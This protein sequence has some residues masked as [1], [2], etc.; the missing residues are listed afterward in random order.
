MKR[1]AEKVK[2]IVEICPFTHLHDFA[3]DPGLTLASYHFTDITADLMSKWIDRASGVRTGQGAALALA[4]FRGVGK[5]HFISVLAAIVSRPELRSRI[6]DGYV[7]SS[8]ERLSRRHGPVAFVRRG[9]GTSL[10]DELKRAVGLILEVNPSTLSDSLYDL[11]LRASEQAGEL[12]LVLLIDTALGRDSR[13]ARDDGILLSEIADAARTLGIF[14]GVALD[15]DISGADGP[16]ASIA[17]SFNIDYLDQEHLY[18]IVDSHIFSKHSHMLPVLHDIYE[19]YRAALPGFRWSEQR[20]T[21]LYPLHPATVEIAPLIRL[22]IHD[23]ALLGFAAEAG[24]KI[25]G[26]PANSLIGIDEVFDSVESKLRH[27]PALAEAFAAFEKLEREVVSKTPV[28][29]RHP[30]KLILKGLLMLS[31]NGEGAS[32]PE[33]AASMMIFHDQSSAAPSLDIQAL[34]DSF[35]DALP[36][37]VVKVV[38]DTLS[39]KY[40][41]KLKTKLDFDGVLAESVDRVPDELIWNILLSQTAEKY[42]DFDA[43]KDLGLHPTICSVEWRGAV[44]RGE[45]VWNPRVAGDEIHAREELLDWSIHVAF[46]TGFAPLAVN[47]AIIWKL[48]EIANDEKDIIRRYYLLHNDPDVREQFGEGLS[49]A[50][51]MHSIAV[52][53]IWQRVFLLDGALTANDQKYQFTEEAQS[54]HSLTQLFT[55]MLAPVFKSQYPSHPEFLE[56]LDMKQS[57]SLV[58]NFFSGSGLNNADAQ[59]LAETFAYPLGLA[60]KNGDVYV[61]VSSETLIELDI[62]KSAFEGSESDEVL[63]L[64]QISERLSAPPTGLTRD[65]QHLIL[66]ALVAQRKYEFVTSSGNRINYRSLDLQIL[67]DDIVGVAKPLNEL[68]SPERLLLWSKLITGNTGLKSLTRSEDRLLIIDSLSGWLSGWK[69]SRTIDEFDA[70]PDENLNA[71]IWR[72]AANLRK[73]F[74]AMADIIDS[75]VKNDLSL[76][77]CL[78]LIADLFSDSEAEFEKKKSDLRILRDFTAD[79]SKRSEIASYLSL[80]EVADDSDLERSRLTLLESISSGQLCANTPENDQ[81]EV[82]WTNFRE[83]YSNYYAEKHDLVMNSVA[84]GEKLREIIRS[85]EWSTFESFSMISWVDQRYFTKAKTLIR[86][87]RQLYCNTKVRESLS[88]KPYC[89]CSFSLSETR[90]LIDLPKQLHK[91]VNSGL[92]SFRSRYVENTKNLI[93]AA[94]SDAMATSIKTILSNFNDSESFSTLSSQDI[95]ILKLAAERITEEKVTDNVISDDEFADDFSP[96]MHLWEQEVEQLEAFVNTER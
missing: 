78:Q 85:D 24:V 15:D 48:A 6:S 80:C 93:D 74:G 9:S 23:F 5:S 65:A 79:V 10:L 77:E 57:S 38:N 52:E 92:E 19:D 22:Y 1:V 35:V 26:R 34:L 13:V 12:P 20:F 47:S 71:G 8:A 95:R 86:E 62:V 28:Q 27:V 73:S 31:L 30:A 43:S 90:R 40:S 89:G 94:D 55:L 50:M 29:F 60:V 61:P 2:D 37:S 39:P 69:Q 21:S 68:Y 25:L 4:G 91:T 63:P 45:I 36:K 18:K 33:I 84:S 81:I 70:L 49:T 16:N 46:G 67:W 83:M 41:F 66:A 75:L 58:A 53:K 17:G 54:A 14:V 7:A 32:A 11:L 72:T 56:H 88:T 3:A 51:H 87:I 64:K 96:A 82:V 44:R 76:D 59:K 42:S